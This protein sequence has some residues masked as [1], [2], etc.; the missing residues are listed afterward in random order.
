M[1]KIKSLSLI[2]FKSY[3]SFSK[4]IN[5]KN[6]VLTGPNGSGKTNILEALSFFS[7]S[8]G[9]RSEK[10]NNQ[11]KKNSNG[12]AIVNIN[13]ESNNL[14]YK[15]TYEV[16]NSNN[17]IKKKFKSD[18]KIV[19]QSTIRKII[20]FIWLSP[21][22]DNIMYEGKSIKR[23][24]LDKL[25]SQYNLNFVTLINEYKTLSNERIK[26]LNIEKDSSWL[27]ILE[28]KIS[29]IMY[30]IFFTRRYY[31]SL[32]ND[33]SSKELFNFRKFIIKYE[34][35]FEAEIKNR[36][37]CLKI[38]EDIILKNR[39]IDELSKRNTFG[40]NNDDISFFD[41]IKK[42]SSD[43]LSTGEQKSILLS[44]ILSN[45]HLYKNNNQNFIMLFDE[46][47]SHIDVNN[48]R[49]FFSEIDKFD[50]QTWYTGT[51]KILFQAI[52]N[53]AFFIEIG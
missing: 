1:A 50:T 4:V 7:N 9:L 17:E 23:K 43:L 45:C 39:T 46:I 41:I 30:D 21:S 40:I 20:K 13:L 5:S 28:S 32:I 27:K 19:N 6:I 35:P 26:I 42:I 53:K 49:K 8:K 12:I 11:I 37:K 38:I 52:E 24:F 3:S 10:L 33:I 2:N 31:A 36:D 14:D 44:I 34:L 15:L 16:I 18:E 22:M 25:I 48:M 29:K 51:D 47:S